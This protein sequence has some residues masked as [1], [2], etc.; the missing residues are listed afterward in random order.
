M[1]YMNLKSAFKKDG[2]PICRLLREQEER[3]FFNLLYENVNDGPTRGLI[4]DS[5]GLC[6]YHAWELQARELKEWNDGLGTG[7]IYEDLA[8]RVLN[9]LS[10]YLSPLKQHLFEKYKDSKTGIN[11]QPG[12]KTD[13]GRTG[14][15]KSF[16]PGKYIL[17]IINAV[18]KKKKPSEALAERLSPEKE[19]HICKSLNQS[20]EAYLEWLVS[21]LFAPEFREAYLASGGLCLPHLRKIL[22]FVEEKWA[23]YILIDKAKRELKV[24][25]NNLKEYVRKHAWDFRF[26]PKYPEEQA[27]WIRAVAFFA[28]EYRGNAADTVIS[29]REKALYDYGR[30]SPHHPT[31]T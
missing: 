15:R 8:G 18:T 30:H 27:S 21:G 11:G 28:G 24:L 14:R 4:I 31:E 10:H 13:A 25:D 17:K 22:K 26:E 23:A 2:C 5:M 3:Y 6:S 9:E 29:T 19:C 1:I 20:E 12:S 16:L 7:I